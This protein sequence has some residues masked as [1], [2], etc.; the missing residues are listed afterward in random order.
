MLCLSFVGHLSAPNDRLI[1]RGHHSISIHAQ[2]LDLRSK[3]VITR[4]PDFTI[5]WG[6][7]QGRTRSAK[8][9]KC[10]MICFLRLPKP[11]PSI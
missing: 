5:P 1:P 11:S 9:I 7:R 4:K 10:V 8:V 6:S 3:D 2:V